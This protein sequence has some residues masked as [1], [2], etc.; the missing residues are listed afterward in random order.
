MP[1]HKQGRTRQLYRQTR[2]GGKEKRERERE[3]RIKIQDTHSN[4]APDLRTS[5]S[6][7]PHLGEERTTGAAS[8]SVSIGLSR[9]RRHYRGDIEEGLVSRR[10]ERDVAKKLGYLVAVPRPFPPRLITVDRPIP[11]TF[12]ARSSPDS[13]RETPE[14]RLFRCAARPPTCVYPPTLPIL[15]S[16]ISTY[17]PT[18][19]LA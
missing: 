9:L 12:L 15:T 1:L 7:M 4:G 17:P 10:V 18:P 6:R 13:P 19:D 8:P 5:V 2:G 3:P 16:S 11:D 14:T